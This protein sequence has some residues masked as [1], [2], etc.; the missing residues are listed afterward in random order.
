MSTDAERQEAPRGSSGLKTYF[1][2]EGKHSEGRGRRGRSTST[3]NEV[4]GL[5]GESGCGKSVTALS[6]MRLDARTRPGWIESRRRSS[7]T[8]KDLRPGSRTTQMRAVRGNEIS[9]IFQE[10]LTSL[11]PVFTVGNQVAEAVMVHQG[12]S[13]S[14]ARERVLETFTQVR[15][16]EP[17]QR[18]GQYPHE[19][20][21]GMRQRVMIAMALACEPIAYS[22]PTNPPPRSTSP[23]RHRSWASCKRFEKRRAL[24][25]SSLPTTWVLWPRSPT[26]SWL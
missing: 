15:I 4:F 9:M 2:I 16:P 26:T 17:E 20:S 12:T 25:S 5:V 8:G 18:M 1:D 22:S 13:K 21:G 23:S 10:P 24:R 11:N 6:I 7:S 19:M 3:R 14:E